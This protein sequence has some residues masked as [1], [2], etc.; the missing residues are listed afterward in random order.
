MPRDDTEHG[1]AVVVFGAYRT[2]LEQDC[3]RRTRPDPRLYLNVE[4]DLEMAEWEALEADGRR[5]A[6]VLLEELL[7]AGEPLIVPRWRVGGNHVPA[8]A[9]VPMFRDRSID[10][11]VVFANDRVAPAEAPVVR[12]W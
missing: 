3:V 4:T 6:A 7:A 2:L 9:D 8:L 1:P 12:W 5:N 11:F 10:A